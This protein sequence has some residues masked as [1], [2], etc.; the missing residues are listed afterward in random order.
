[1]AQH[2]FQLND[3]PALF[4]TGRSVAKGPKSIQQVNHQS[5]IIIIIIVVIIIVYSAPLVK[6][7]KTAVHYS[8]VFVCKKTKS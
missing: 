2:V 3:K 6:I 1:V 8:V 4:T 5:Y 7:I